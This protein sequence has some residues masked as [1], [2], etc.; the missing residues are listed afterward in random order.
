MTRLICVF[1]VSERDAGVDG[2]RGF[3]IL[4]FFI[5]CVFDFDPKCRGETG[6]LRLEDNVISAISQCFEIHKFRL[7][8][9]DTDNHTLHFSVGSRS[10]D[11]VI[12][13]LNRLKNLLKRI[14]FASLV[15]KRANGR[16][17][18]DI[19]DIVLSFGLSAINGTI[20]ELPSTYMFV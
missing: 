9:R 1:F 18:S 13:D 17:I 6:R 11:E 10:C 7:I 3:A 15:G 16:E 20:P 8:R 12:T 4:T 2:R 19:N 5:T 14:C